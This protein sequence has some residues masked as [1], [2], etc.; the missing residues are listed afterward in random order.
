MMPSQL[1]LE[2]ELYN[3]QSLI[4]HRAPVV[5]ILQLVKTNGCKSDDLGVEIYLHSDIREIF[6]LLIHVMT[7]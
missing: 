3:L 4:S 5:L 2:S 1:F 7:S 6:H